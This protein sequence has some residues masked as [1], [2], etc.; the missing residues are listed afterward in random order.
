MN[1]LVPMNEVCEPKR[2]DPVMDTILGN[3]QRNKQRL[4]ERLAKVQAGLD[5]LEKN[6]ELA[7]TLETIQQALRA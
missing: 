3:L 7:A 5:A 1:E 6:P 2:C 4:N